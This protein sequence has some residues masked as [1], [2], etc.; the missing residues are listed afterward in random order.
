MRLLPI[1]AALTISLPAISAAASGDQPGEFSIRATI[2]LD[3][4]QIESLRGLI[5]SEKDAQELVEKLETEAKKHLGDEPTPLVKI[6]YEGLVNT[7]PKRI[8]AVDSLRQMDHTA[9]LLRYWQ[10][11]NSPEAAATLKQIIL[12]WSA[13]YIPTGN[14]VN[15]N[16]LH[17]LLNAYEALRD[18]SFSENESKAV[19]D[20]VTRLGRHHLGAVKH[21]DFMTN[22]YTKHLRLL[23]I[24]G[25]IL[26]KDEWQKQTI[27]GLK[28]F[29]TESLRADGTSLD[30][31]R[32]DTLT[33]HCSALRP[34]IELCV[35]AGKEGFELYAWESENGGSIKKS[36]DY[37]VPYANG[38]KT[39]EEWKN[40][41]VELDRKR[42]AAGIEAYRAGRLFDPIDA[43]RVLEEAT[44]FDKSLLPLAHDLHGESGSKYPSWTLMVNEAISA[45]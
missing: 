15:E 8:A 37:V 20:W 26:G 22:R 13:T 1:F 42:A 25:R 33:Y 16:K 4:T 12:A 19:D 43:L 38:T 7:N 39:R 40:T 9:L 23:A 45:K 17:P 3:D 2:P 14:D 18:S 5:A 10:A 24:C 44:F 35:L 21:S 36:I 11:T 34:P 31:E 41:T 27:T 28:R 6:D 32:R 29:V 30:L